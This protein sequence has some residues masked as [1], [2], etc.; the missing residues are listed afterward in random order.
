MVLNADQERASLSQNK[1]NL[2]IAS[3][4]TG[5]TSTIIAR[6]V[7]LLKNGLKPHQIILLTF[8]SKAGKEML[9]RLEKF[10]PSSDVSQIFA[11]TFHAYGKALMAKDNK[12]VKLV[13]DKEIK[14]LLESIV[15]SPEF[16]DALENPYSASIV[17]EHIGLFENTRQSESFSQWLQK[18][19]SL[20]LDTASESEEMRLQHHIDNIH[21]Y[22]EMYQKYIKEKSS[23][24][25]CDFNDLLK[26]IV[27][28]YSSHTSPIREVIVDEY[29]D[30]NSLQNKVLEYLARKGSGVF[31][32]GDYDQSIYGFN[33]SDVGVIK[34][35]PQKYKDVAIYNLSK[36]YRSSSKILDLANYGIEHNERIIPKSLEPMKKGSFDDPTCYVYEKADQ[37]YDEVMNFIRS[38]EYEYK[39]VA[40]LFRGNISGDSIEARLIGEGIPF[41]RAKS[42]GF[43]DGN[44]ISALLSLYK[45][46]TDHHPSVAD[47]IHLSYF[48]RGAQQ[49]D[50]RDLSSVVS[51]SKRINMAIVS[52][53]S[54]RSKKSIS[55]F[56]NKNIKN[57]VQ[58]LKRLSSQKTPKSFFQELYQSSEYGYFFDTLMKTAAKYTKEDKLPEKIEEFE[59]KHK[60]LLKIAGDCKTFNAFNRK[61]FYSSSKSDTEE[62]VNL[63]SVHGSKGLEFKCVLLIDL[64]EGRFPNTKLAD[65]RWGSIAEERRLFYVALT[66]AEEKLILFSFRKTNRGKFVISR[67]VQECRAEVQNI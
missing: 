24:G 2:V 44:A 56:S 10:L 67:F 45:I 41:S 49:H 35:F 21:V 33:G 3:A 62:G 64:V 19:F 18:E 16:K 4:G 31:A 11:G 25:I 7:H 54:K 36:N 34:R 6:V 32:V 39:D 1:N 12:K 27:V 40:V 52:E 20:S 61:A 38:K 22:E 66:R 60:L 47:I 9:E 57:F 15:K 63:L 26:Y 30:T 59:S 50:L 8:T 58:T 13:V 48:I 5:K 23:H 55:L 29:Q 65:G 43:F 28:Y 51:S 37:Q 17:A 46:G 53:M 14:L 42:K